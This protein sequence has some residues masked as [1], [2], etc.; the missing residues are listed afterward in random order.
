[1]N[2]KIRFGILGAGNIAHKFAV[3]LGFVKDAEI[4]AVASRSIDKANDFANKFNIK[5]RYASYEELAT[6]DEIDVIYICTPNSLHKEHAILCFENKK[7]VICEKPLAVTKADAEEM[8]KS[9]RENQVFFMEAMWVRFFP[10]NKKVKELVD[11]GVIGKVKMIQADFGFKAAPGYN[12]IRFNKELGGGSIFDV[13]IYPISFASM[14]YKKQPTEMKVMTDIG[15]S[16]VDESAAMIFGY[17]KHEMAVLN[18]SLRYETPRSV[19]IIG[20]DGYIH[21]PNTWYAE[22]VIVAVNG[23]DKQVIDMPI[24]GNGYNYEVEEVV[25]CLQEGKLES[26]IMTLQESLDIMGTVDRIMNI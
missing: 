8:V 20:E 14:I 24:E 11:D 1:M 19:N 18:S 6:D 16:G 7:A 23:Q 10:A 3:G 15:G 26:E 5:N 22:K 12:D 9:A 13:G 17:D 2:K 4:T 25:K 21:I